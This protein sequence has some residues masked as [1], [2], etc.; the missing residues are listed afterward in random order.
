MARILSV[1]YDKALLTNATL[2]ASGHSVTSAFGYTESLH[3]CKRGGF[4]LFILGH[5]I[6][7]TDKQALIEA[8][9]QA[10]PGVIVSLRKPNESDAFGADYYI[11]P[12]P[13]ALLDIVAKI[14]GEGEVRPS[15]WE[16]PGSNRNGSRR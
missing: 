16:W 11:D 4:D 6:S 3:Q 7:Q 13:N 12:A 5:S 14:L 8:F 15:Y 9:H 2:E 1:S 10:C